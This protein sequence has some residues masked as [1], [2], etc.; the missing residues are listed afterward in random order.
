MFR[1]LLQPT[2]SETKEILANARKSVPLRF[3]TSNQFL[4]GQHAGCA[5]TIGVM[6]RCDFACKA[7]YL[8]KE[9]NRIPMESVAGVKEQLN[10]IRA[11]LGLGG[12]VQITDGEVTLRPIDDLLEIIRYAKAIDLVPMLMTHGDVLRKN[13]Q[14]LRRLILEADLSEISIHIDTTQRGRLGKA[15]R[16]AKQESELMPLRDE[17]AQLIR[18]VRKETGKPLKVAMTITVTKHNLCGVAE[19]VRWSSKNSDIV[20]LLSF[21][22]VT[23]VGR[24]LDDVSASVNIESLWGNIAVG[25]YDDEK[26]QCDL[27]NHKGYLGHADCTRFVQ[28]LVVRETGRAPTFHPLFRGIGSPDQEFLE[29]FLQRFGGSSTRIGKSWLAYTK[30]F[31][32]LACAPVF[33]FQSL[34]PFIVRKLKELKSCHGIGLFGRIVIGRAQINYLNIISHHFMNR[35]EID[36]PH[37]QERLQ[38]C[39]FKVPL[40]GE[41]ISMCAANAKGY[42]ENYY[43]QLR[44]DNVLRPVHSKEH[45]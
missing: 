10:Q 5:A 28:G 35:D 6:P 33:V 1:S 16:Y 14:L 37:G 4:G 9:A 7:C 45:V 38:A 21:Q 20:T 29:S 34:L 25:V 32:M 40:N 23:Q 12:N 43:E 36:T 24:T 19:I 41:M 15:Y 3:R 30:L 8:G 11:W 27:L 22:P 2:L 39:V 44:K 42:R 18:D 17:F 13:P 31:F 26:E